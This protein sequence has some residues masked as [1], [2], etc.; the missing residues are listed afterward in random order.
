MEPN[1]TIKSTGS[2]SAKEETAAEKA[3]EQ[4]TKQ[5]RLAALEKEAREIFERADKL[6]LFKEI[7]GVLYLDNYRMFP[8]EKMVNYLTNNPFDRD[9]LAERI[10]YVEAQPPPKKKMSFREKLRK[11]KDILKS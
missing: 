1:S 10:E 8:R 4:T 11:I 5:A 9:A 3:N 2:S 6:G 7:D